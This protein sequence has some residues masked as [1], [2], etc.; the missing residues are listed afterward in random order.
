MS[1]GPFVTQLT[2]LFQGTV[3]DPCLASFPP[4]PQE[5]KLTE[6]AMKSP[7]NDTYESPLSEFR[8][9]LRRQ[10]GTVDVCCT[11]PEW[12]LGPGPLC[13][14][15]SLAPL[16]LSLISC[17]PCQPGCSRRKRVACRGFFEKG[18]TGTLS[19]KYSYVKASFPKRGMPGIQGDWKLLSEPR[20]SLLCRPEMVVSQ[21]PKCLSRPPGNNCRSWP[22][23]PPWHIWAL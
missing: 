4:P 13:D 9:S 7:Q 5:S 11:S 10:K 23:T 19:S 22:S 8:S 21:G 16:C 14:V 18:Y 1:R 15:G 3:G 6:K 12:R 17:I 20:R 2:S